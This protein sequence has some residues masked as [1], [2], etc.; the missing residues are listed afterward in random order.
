M[1]KAK[2]T[3]G[4]TV[5]FEPKYQDKIRRGA[6]NLAISTWVRTLVLRELGAR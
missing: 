5:W 4:I 1:A 2:K 3:Y 6:G